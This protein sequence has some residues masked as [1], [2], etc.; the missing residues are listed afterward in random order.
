MKIN[1]DPGVRELKTVDKK[2]QV[3]PGQDKGRAREGD[4]VDFSKELQQARNSNSLIDDAARQE[5]VQAVK[6]QIA[7]GTYSPDSQKVAE[8]LLKFIAE[9]RSNG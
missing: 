6:Q 5:R 9:G 8:S 1:P 2:Q 4:K 7:D 3:K